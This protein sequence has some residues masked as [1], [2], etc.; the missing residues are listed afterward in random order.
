M[1]AVRLFRLHET[2][3]GHGPRRCAGRYFRCLDNAS[4]ARSSSGDAGVPDEASACL[5]LIP[6]VDSRFA[7]V[8]ADVSRFAALVNLPGDFTLKPFIGKRVEVVGDIQLPENVSS[9]PK[10]NE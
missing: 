10:M 1:A 8:S 4:N 9:R 2:G 5:A 7:A 3:I 6:V